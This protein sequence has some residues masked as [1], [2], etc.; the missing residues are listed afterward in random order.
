MKKIF[1]MTL[2]LLI[3]ACVSTEQAKTNGIKFAFEL[4]TRAD[5]I[6]VIET[7]LHYFEN[8]IT[9]NHEMGTAN[10]LRTWACGK[11]TGMY[12]SNKNGKYVDYNSC[13]T[14]QQLMRPEI[15]YECF[16]QDN[17]TIYNSD[18]CILQRRNT[19]PSNVKFFDYQ[20]F[21]GKNSSIQTDEDFL[22]LVLL[23]LKS[24]NCEQVVDSVK[25]ALNKSYA[26]MMDCDNPG[27]KTQAEIETC[28]NKYLEE[29]KTQVKTPH[30]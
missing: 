10:I 2:C 7:Y 3:T 8:G 17:E 24:K 15:T 16:A 6:E 26:E 11:T 23:Y 25:C 21:L 13:L 30:K 19:P 22:K 9:Y 12:P 29:I 4:E 14:A 20:R 27:E 5:P 28:K 18:T 1:C